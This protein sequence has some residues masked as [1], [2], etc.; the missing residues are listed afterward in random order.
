MKSILLSLFIMSI[1]VSFASSQVVCSE[2]ELVREILEDLADNGK[3]DCLRKSK[4]PEDGKE[5][6]EQKRLRIAAE[7]N[8]DCSFESNGANWVEKLK[9]NYNLEKGLIDANG[10]EYKE[11]FAD[12][13]D[14]CEIIRTL[15]GNGKFPAL[16]T[17]VNHI[18]TRIVDYINCPGGDG[19]TRVCAVTGRSFADKDSWYILLDGK[20]ITANDE[21]KFELTK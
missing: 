8:S 15:V 12:Q 7:W 2:D 6:D 1:V 3:L 9:K 21:P 10:V 13:A 14:M 5:T 19:Q 16:G 4:A 18:S 11:N 20:S 17:D